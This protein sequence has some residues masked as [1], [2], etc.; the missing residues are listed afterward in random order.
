M[1][2]VSRPLCPDCASACPKSWRRHWAGESEKVR[3]G[4]R[5]GV[6]CDLF[7]LRINFRRY[8][9][10][11]D[12]YSGDASDSF[13]TSANMRNIDGMP[14]STIDN[15]HDFNTGSGCARSHGAGWWYNDCAFGE[16]NGAGTT[17]FR[18]FYSAASGFMLQT[19]RM[20]VKPVE[21]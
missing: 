2:P 17:Y 3:E 9:I 8:R 6:R 4:V 18:W 13:L 20:M 5:G 1:C 11:L 10:H 14:F 21:K 19:S 12:G 15:R 16:P 7:Y